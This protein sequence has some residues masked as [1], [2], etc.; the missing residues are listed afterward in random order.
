MGKQRIT[1]GAILEIAVG[2]KYYYAQILHCKNYVF[3]DYVSSTHLK[4][5]A[6]LLDKPAL[7]YVGVYDDIV[8]D[9][10]WVKIGNLPIRSEFQTVPMQF[11]Q[12][13]HEKIEF[14]LYNPNT[15]EIV[16]AK[17]EDCIGLE[18][19]A[20]WDKEHVE[21]RLEDYYNGVPNKWVEDMKIR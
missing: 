17:K 11:I 12:H 1:K 2:N 15:G 8:I 10:Y 5:L 6:V 18:C 19:C 3:F 13:P 9:G 20:V 7:F 21:Q 4:D 16:N 14:E